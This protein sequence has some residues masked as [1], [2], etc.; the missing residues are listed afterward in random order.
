L[1]LDLKQKR[2]WKC[3]V[4]RG[5][6]FGSF[7]CVVVAVWFSNEEGT[8][9]KKEDEAEEI[10]KGEGKEEGWCGDEKGI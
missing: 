1:I 7:L 4:I 8:K 3:G 5:F 6:D 9:R 2:N 10:E